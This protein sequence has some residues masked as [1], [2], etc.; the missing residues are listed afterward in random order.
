[1]YRI[2]LG[3]THPRKMRMNT[4]PLRYGEGIKNAIVAA[5]VGSMTANFVIPN[6]VFVSLRLL[7]L[8]FGAYQA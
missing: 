7:L 1:M 2:N 6:G 4:V 8:A 3:L 5:G